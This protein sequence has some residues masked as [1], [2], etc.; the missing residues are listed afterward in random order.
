MRIEHATYY[1]VISHSS[2]HQ[3]NYSFKTI[4]LSLFNLYLIFD[5]RIEVEHILLYTL[6]TVTSFA[7]LTILIAVYLFVSS[8]V[9]GAQQHLC[10]H[11]IAST[12]MP[13]DLF[14]FSNCTYNLFISF[15]M[16]SRLID[17]VKCATHMHFNSS[18]IHIELHCKC[19]HIFLMRIL[20]NFANW[21]IENE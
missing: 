8:F 15:S 13:I 5:H 14:V 12:P 11:R 9:Q 6:Y 21:K 3:W 4:C 10:L 7:L 16:H 17:R 2:Y 1:I 18:Y 19:I 20:I